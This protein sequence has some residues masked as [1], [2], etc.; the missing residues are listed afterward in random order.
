MWNNSGL[1]ILWGGGG[2]GLW[3]YAPKEDFQFS[4]LIR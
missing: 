4:C 1:R 3:G 2:G